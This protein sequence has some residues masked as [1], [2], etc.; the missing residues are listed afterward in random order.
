M[1][2]ISSDLYPSKQSMMT[3]SNF[4]KVVAYSNHFSININKS[5]KFTEW[6]LKIIKAEQAQN[7]SSD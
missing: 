7:Y 2:K 6:H 4:K 1:Q 3:N 5:Q